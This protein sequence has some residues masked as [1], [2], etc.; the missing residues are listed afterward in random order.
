[1]SLPTP[2]SGLRALVL[3]LVPLL[4]IGTLLVSSPAQAQRVS[5][6][7][8]GMHDANI[9]GGSLPAV[10][11]GSVRLWDTGTAWRQIEKRPGRFDFRALDTAVNT[12]LNA[13]LRPMVVLGQTPRFYASKPKAAGWYGAGAS[14][15]P[16]NV[17][18][19]KRY[20]TKVAKRYK[21]SVDYQI[22]NEPNVIGFWSGTVGQ[23]AKLT[24][25]GSVAINK[26]AGRKATIV[27]PSFPLRLKS[28]QKWFK[29][30]WAAKVGGKSVAR[31]VDVVS[32]NPYPLADQGPEAS[33]KLLAF[34]KRVLP[35]QARRKPLWNTEINY[36]LLGGDTAKRIPEATQAAYVARTLLLNA[37]GSI[38]RMYWYSWRINGIANTH[39]VEDDGTTLTRAGRA[40][41]VVRGW[42]VDTDVTC[43]VTARGQLKGLYTC[44]ARVG[45]DEVRRIYWKPTGGAV[46]VTTSN[47]TTSWTDLDGATTTHVGPLTLTVNNA[48]VM[49]SSLN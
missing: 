30:Y 39:L 27:A 44:T 11:V 5:P 32:A 24:A 46:P 3:G 7:F 34:A 2:R 21:T 29:K 49:V 35:Q 14:S 12:A 16:K 10:T 26:A 22:W 42:I 25:T 41:Q 36:G 19:W 20:V 45:A 31:M 48:P 13:G 15:M 1:M 43:A 23:M 17:S 40:W 8:F 37:G 9:A 6:S 28:Q 47:T 33:M 38:K 18:A 4:M